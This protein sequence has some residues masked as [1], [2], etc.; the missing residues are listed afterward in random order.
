MAGQVIS[1]N[2]LPEPVLDHGRVDVVV[3]NP[4]FISRVI[5]RV[6][7]NALDLARVCWQK[8]FKGLQ[9]VAVDN[10]VVIQFRLIREVKNLLQTEKFDSPKPVKLLTRI[11]EVAT[12]KNSIILD[13]YAGSG[14][15]AQAV[16]ALNKED[17]GNRRFIL[18]ECEDY[19]DKI[20]AERVRRVIR[21][22][23]KAKDEDL[24]KGLGGTFS[25]FELGKPIE[26]SGILSGKNLP[27]YLELARYVFYT[28]TGQDFDEKK[29]DEKRSFIGQTKE[30]EVYLI[31][32][33]DVE[34]LKKTALT[35]DAA[36]SLGPLNGK[37][38]LVFAPAK[39]LDQDQLAQF[40]IDFS[41]LPFEIYKLAG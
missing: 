28:A 7:I 26:A 8:R 31:Y 16:L 1:V 38:R 33:P 34:Y 21:G 18:V 22:V 17:G 3:V 36:R 12:D 41:Q 15:T 19:A 32:K 2:D 10:K 35:L 5:G 13:S 27:S 14:T 4:V 37:R 9:I 24:K 23:P 11:L 6:D 20:T 25:Y 39:Y 30:R 40:R 29:L